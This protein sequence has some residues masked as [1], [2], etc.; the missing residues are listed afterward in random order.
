MTPWQ[1]AKDSESSQQIALF[2]YAAKAMQIGFKLAKE[3]GCYGGKVVYVDPV[4][5]VPELKWLHHI[6]NG[7]SRGDSQKSRA[8]AGGLLK[9]EGVRS[10]VLDICW[11]LSR[12]GNLDYCGL[13]IEM[14]KPS[15]KSAKN[16][17]AGCSPEQM[18]FGVFVIE[19][20]YQ[21]VVCYDWLEAASAIEAYY[22]LG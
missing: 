21:A 4:L 9:A 6:P 14:K 7:G 12:K 18:E 15:L 16:P 17:Q 2:C 11:P 19:Q 8:I 22:N 5:P 1:L 10:G 13:Y 20:G 3:P